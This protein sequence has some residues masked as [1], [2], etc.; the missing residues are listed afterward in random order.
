MQRNAIARLGIAAALT[1]ALAGC[2]D[3]PAQTLD[4]PATVT[5]TA[6]ETASSPDESPTDA[7]P[8]A[9][10]AEDFEASVTD[11]QGAAGSTVFTI[12]LEYMGSDECVLEGFPGVSAVGGGHGEQIGEPAARMDA[13]VKS[14]TMASGAA[15]TFSIEAVNVGENGG[16]LGDDCDATVADGW[17]IY[18]PNAEDAIFVEVDDLYACAADVDWLSV[19]PVDAAA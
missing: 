4:P 8:G 19:S 1:L 5:E 12:G 3:E 2:A 15:A 13:E 16:P 18:P 9:C 11:Q 7:A 17:R 6:T 10:A 14:I